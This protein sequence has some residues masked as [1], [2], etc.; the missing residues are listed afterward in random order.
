MNLNNLTKEEL[1]NV[2]AN[3]HAL[4]GANWD[5]KFGNCLSASEKD[6]N[7]LNTIGNL[8]FDKCLSDNDWKLPEHIVNS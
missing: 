3:M 8:C 1:I 5:R 6:A 2:V 4:V 7:I